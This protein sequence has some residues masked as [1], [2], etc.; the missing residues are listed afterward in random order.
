MS[1]KIYFR[2]A[3]QCREHWNNHLDPNKIKGNWTPEEF[4]L[5]FKMV[6]E[7]GKKWANLVKKF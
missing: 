6:K 2:T 4:L 1:N 7:D 5:M 3:K